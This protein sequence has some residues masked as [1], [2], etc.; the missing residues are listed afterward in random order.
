MRLVL[1]DA[2]EIDCPSV[3]EVSMLRTIVI[4]VFT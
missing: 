2:R 4:N 1:V 3:G